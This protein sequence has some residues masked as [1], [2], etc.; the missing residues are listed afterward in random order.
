MIS[1][2]GLICLFFAIAQSGAIATA[3]TEAELKARV[4]EASKN[5]RDVTITCVVREKN[6]AALSKVD[7]NYARLY[8][9]SSATIAIKAP[10]KLHIESKLG[11]VKFEYIINN[12]KKIFRAP[13]IKMNKVEDYSNDPAK[14][15][16]P[17]DIG[18]VTPQLWQNRRV[19]VID[20]PEAAANGEIKLKLSWPK[21]NMINYA[22]IDATNFY[23]KKFEKRDEKNNLQARMV[24]SNPKN[25][26]GVIWVPTRVELYTSD[27]TKAGATEFTDIKANANLP[28]TLFN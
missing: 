22:W 26:D 12:G 13:K 16:Y 6:K 21:G 18:L 20:D 28:D 10:D 1:I 17:F 8:D 19:E 23:L 3:I 4:E 24:Y 2:L 15:Q 7:S 11:M 14:L 27:G 5:F 25:I 9:F